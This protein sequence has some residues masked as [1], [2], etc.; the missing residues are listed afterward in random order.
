MS[1]TH[2]NF[3]LLL[4]SKERFISQKKEAW[5]ACTGRISAA[6]IGTQKTDNMDAAHTRS[7]GRKQAPVCGAMLFLPGFKS[8]LWN[9]VETV[10]INDL[11]E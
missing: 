3:H 6:E 9:K 5:L 7:G 4:V 2:C 8:V 11:H 1:L 10:T